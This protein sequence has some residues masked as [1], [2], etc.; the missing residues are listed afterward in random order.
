MRKR[1]PIPALP[2]AIWLV[3][4]ASLTACAG[5][6]EPTKRATDPSQ[7]GEDD[8]GEDDDEPV[9]K[10]DA[11]AAKDAGRPKDAGNKDAGTRDA[12]PPAPSEGDEDESEPASTMQRDAGDA[13]SPNVGDAS[14]PGSGCANSPAAI[15][16]KVRDISIYQTVR[17]QLYKAGAFVAT[18]A[19]P[20]VAGKK[21]LVRVFVDTTT[22]YTKHPVH[23]VLTLTGTAGETTVVDDRTIASASTDADA[24]STFSFEVDPTK[25]EP[26]TQFSVSLQET[27]C[28][29]TGGNAA[30]TRVPATGTRAL[31]AQSVGKLKVVVVP[32]DIAGR[33]PKTDA[34]ELDK[35][36]A[37]LLAYY[38][39]AAVDVTVRATPIKWTGSVAGTDSR[40]W[41]N[42]LNQVL[43]ERSTDNPSSDTYYF[44]LMQPAATMMAYCGRGCILGIA[45]QT[46]RISPSA[47][48]GLGASFADAQTYET[49]VHEL[50][51]AHG[52]GHAPCVQGGSIDGVDMMYPDKTGSIMDWGW[53]SRISKLLSPMM[54]KDVMGYCAPNWISPYT[55]GAL[56]IRSLAVN[57]L[58]FV[59]APLSP[60]TWHN[61]LLY[62]DGSARWGGIVE[63]STPG[64]E[65]ETAT[66]LDAAG[67]SIATVDVLRL[68]L[69]HS[70]DRVLYIPTAG[71]N[72]AK[73]VLRDRVLDLA[74]IQAAL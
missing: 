73:L 3:G 50:G 41:S 8:D 56:A 45:P 65:F 7:R 59:H 43:R 44:G 60:V 61:V 24:T 35:I 38:P 22:G 33:L 2:L 37:A 66:V 71:A 40:G 48:G 5:E 46:T 23:A 32:I 11:G 51:H 54:Y 52:R 26:S 1:P 67:Q 21:A 12:G 39:V 70:E 31:G 72:W 4:F 64:G 30:D 58:A 62:G 28:Q 47:Q 69:S 53:D 17:A 9:V 68:E 19:V 15:G 10:K 55:Y 49:I 29:A 18:P 57:K 34:P 13:S 42:L 20:V 6:I 63:N 16:L 36:K 27:N 25:I 14:K 74:Q